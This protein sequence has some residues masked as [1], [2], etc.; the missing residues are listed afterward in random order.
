MDLH[1]IVRGHERG[2]GRCTPRMW[3][4]SDPPCGARMPRLQSTE[5]RFG[6]VAIAPDYRLFRAGINVTAGRSTD[7]QPS[8]LAEI[9]EADMVRVDELDR[10]AMPELGQ[11]AAHGFDR[12][13]E[14]VGDVVT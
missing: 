14:I 11:G 4:S 12:E 3:P 13:A 5:S 8:G 7:R 6:A 10:T 2:S 9:V 1:L